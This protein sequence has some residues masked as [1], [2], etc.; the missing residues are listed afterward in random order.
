MR[1]FPSL[2]VVALLRRI[3]K[4]LERANAIN[5]ERVRMEFPNSPSAKRLAKT[6]RHTEFSVADPAE[7]NKRYKESRG[8]D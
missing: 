6:P 7:W 1:I 5:E 2:R 4:A 8:E 3:A